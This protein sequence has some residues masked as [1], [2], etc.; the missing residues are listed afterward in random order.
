MFLSGATFDNLD[1]M[2]ICAY[3]LY[4]TEENQLSETEISP[5]ISNREDKLC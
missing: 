4:C 3:A 1:E 2:L 5:S